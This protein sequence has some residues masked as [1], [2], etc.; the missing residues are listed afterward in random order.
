M[1]CQ[2]LCD[3]QPVRIRFFFAHSSQNFGTFPKPSEQ[4][5]RYTLMPGDFPVL[6]L[7]VRQLFEA[8]LKEEDQVIAPCSDLTT[9]CPFE[10]TEPPR[11]VTFHDYKAL[12]KLNHRNLSDTLLTIMTCF[13]YWPFDPLK[14]Q[15]RW[16][17]EAGGWQGTVVE[18]MALF[19]LFQSTFEGGF[20]CFF[21]Y[22]LSFL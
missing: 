12:I 19:Q 14:V 13:H 11:R 5:L 4:R 22:P 8:L 9:L 6:S 1:R 15:G 17:Q 16:T 18:Q 7:W 2:E 20:F 3:C 21:R 10:F